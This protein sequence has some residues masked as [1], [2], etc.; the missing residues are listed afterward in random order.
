MKTKTIAL[1]MLALSAGFCL[2]TNEV[3]WERK[4]MSDC[5]KEEKSCTDSPA[6]CKKES[7][8]CKKDAP[9]TDETSFS[10]QLSPAYKSMFKNFNAGQ[11]M[12]AMDMADKNKMAPDD[13]VA[14]VASA[15]KN[16]KK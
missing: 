13:A 6:S 16:N 2:S 7:A 5:K 3:A 9:K 1:T 4:G 14:K 11:K 12:Q 10:H 8:E 15:S